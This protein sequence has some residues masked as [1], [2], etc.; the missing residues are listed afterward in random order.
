MKISAKTI[1]MA[2]LYKEYLENRAYIPQ[3]Q[4]TKYK[5]AYSLIY[6]QSNSQPQTR[7]YTKTN[8]NQ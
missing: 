1:I 8:Q 4:L 6:N 5:M 2:D 7:E 3:S